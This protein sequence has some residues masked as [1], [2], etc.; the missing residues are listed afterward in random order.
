[1][2]NCQFF[3]NNK[4]LRKEK[5]IIKEQKD[6]FLWFYLYKKIGLQGGG[7]YFLLCR[8]VEGCF[9]KIPPEPEAFLINSMP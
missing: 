1:M 5:R 8:G 6:S 7:R 9:Q 3:F 4:K 2:P